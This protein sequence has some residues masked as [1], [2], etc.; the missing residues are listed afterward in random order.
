MFWKAWNNYLYWSR[1]FYALNLPLRQLLTGTGFLLSAHR[2][3]F[4]AFHETLGSQTTDYK[5]PLSTGKY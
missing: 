2:E 1:G 5:M 3:L 4:F